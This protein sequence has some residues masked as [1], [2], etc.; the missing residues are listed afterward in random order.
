MLD[1]PYSLCAK[2]ENNSGSTL[3]LKSQ[4]TLN[5]DVLPP[6]V[7][8]DVVIDTAGIFADGSISAAEHAAATNV[9]TTNVNA[10]GADIIGYAFVSSGDGCNTVAGYNNP[11]FSND[12]SITGNGT[13]KVC[14]KLQ[15][16]AGNIAYDEMSPPIL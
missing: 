10:T 7:S 8:T 9:V 3:Y 11:L 1:G 2:L 13:Y 6:S 12:A 15:D 5:R 16:N 14:A 4:S